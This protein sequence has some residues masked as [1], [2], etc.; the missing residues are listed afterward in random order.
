MDIEK[1]NFELALFEANKLL[2][3]EGLIETFPFQAKRL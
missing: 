3:Q 1:P 2:L